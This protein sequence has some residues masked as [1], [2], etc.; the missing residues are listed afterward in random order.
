MPPDGFR[1]SQVRRASCRLTE[2]RRASRFPEGPGRLQSRVWLAVSS[3]LSSAR[4]RSERPKLSR[5]S[6][7][8]RKICHLSDVLA[9]S[10]G[11]RLPF[12]LSR[13][14]AIC[15]SVRDRRP[16]GAIGVWVA[17]SF[18][19]FSQGKRNPLRQNDGQILDSDSGKCDSEFA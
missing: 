1:P 17:M 19:P 13:R 6:V 10:S 7:R 9:P 16:K 15:P 18:L 5:I 4:L 8:V 2:R 14:L 12:C 3:A 11:A